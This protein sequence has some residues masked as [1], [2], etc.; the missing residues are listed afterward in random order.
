[1]KMRVTFQ[2]KGNNTK[3]QHKIIKSDDLDEWINKNKSKTR[4]IKSKKYTGGGHF[5]RVEFTGMEESLRSLSN[6]SARYN[7]AVDEVSYVTLGTRD[8]AD[9]V[10][11]PDRPVRR[12]QR[13]GWREIGRT[14]IPTR[15]E[16]DLPEP[17]ELPNRW[18]P[19]EDSIW[20]TPVTHTVTRNV[21][22]TFYGDV[23][24][25]SASG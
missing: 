15:V 21:N 24:S 13:S 10:V 25:G 18:T 2:W 6:A 3:I 1:M 5:T 11:L 12:E 22:G 9:P 8:E 20:T 16:E 4:F 17:Q 14:T 19:T 23:L 7:T